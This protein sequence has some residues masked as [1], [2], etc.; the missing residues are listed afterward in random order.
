M[1]VFF[2]MW[3]SIAILQLGYWGIVFQRLVWY[4]PLQNHTI[5]SFPGVSIIICARNE[6]ANLQKNLESILLQDYPIFEVIVVNDDSSDE[7]LDVLRTYEGQFT[8]LKVVH[9]RNK[10][11][12]GK[13]EALTKGIAQAKYPWILLTD[14]DCKA[15]SSNWIRQMYQQAE[16]SKSAIVL[17]Y[18]PYTRAK[19]WLN[20]WVQFETI[21]VAIQYLSF[22]LWKIP[23]MGVGRNLMYRKSLFIQE[24]GFERHQ[25]IASGDDDLFINAVANN[26][27]TAI[28]LHEDSFMYSNPPNSWKALYRQKQRHYSTSTT[29]KFK[30][31]ILL[32]LLS[33][34]HFCFYLGLCI[35][36]I[37]NNWTNSIVGII[38][39]RTLLMHLVF[40]KYLRKVKQR[41]FLKYV[42]I[43][44]ALLPI[45]YI[46]FASSLMGQQNKTWK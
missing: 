44:D 16:T 28:C 37:T 29:Y 10:Q 7:S 5:C 13:K 38:L 20:R 2:I 31:K 33:V 12:Q 45:Y 24:N 43:L 26:H 4:R 42:L 17:G 19:T 6:A 23:Y 39:L 41:S 18:G 36:I 21:Y 25:H 32:G 30:H 27:N 14:A 15:A 9:L 8:H 3:Y 22:A 35:F 34:S 46:I 1:D 11:R 40:G